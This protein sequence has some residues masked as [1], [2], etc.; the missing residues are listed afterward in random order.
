MILRRLTKHI[1][2]QNWFAVGLDFV[3]VVVGI[4]I[5]FQITNWNENRA[6]RA[7]EVRYLSSMKRDVESS[8]RILNDSI[9]N[10][11]R[12]Q[13]ARQALY[14][15]HAE[16]AAVMESDELDKLIADGLFSL[17]R[18]NLNQTT[19]ETLKSSG[20]MSMIKSSE[21]VKALQDLSAKIDKA[22]V[23]KNEDFQFTYRIVD[24]LLIG[25]GDFDN[26]LMLDLSSIHNR[27]PWVTK[28][29]GAGY[30]SDLVRSQRFKN[31]MLYK[32]LYGQLRLEGFRS[33]LEQHKLILS[34][35]DEH[36]VKLGVT[37]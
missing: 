26:I 18:A 8:I 13:N 5:A 31:I 9:A 15:F 16:P 37:P 28:Q 10:L 24:P 36:Q 1:K 30:S 14:T 6:E 3:I 7:Q 19:F 27:L 32:A 4:L 35:I 25:E 20:Q 21:L 17:E 11:Q 22:E 34:L 33:I 29:P 23:D 2:D 12:Q